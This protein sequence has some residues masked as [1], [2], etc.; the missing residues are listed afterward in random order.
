MYQIITVYLVFVIIGLCSSSHIGFGILYG[1]LA[2][3]DEKKW[4][5]SSVWIWRRC[6]DGSC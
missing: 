5:P 4:Q 3:S 1:H 2:F 6:F